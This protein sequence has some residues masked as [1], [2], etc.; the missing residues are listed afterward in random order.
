MIKYHYDLEQGSEEWLEAR[1]GIL[2]A[3]EMK[4]ILTP[5]L[6]IAN[7][8]KVRAH[9][10]E[11]LAQRETGYVEPSYISDDM[12]RGM[13]DEETARQL[14][15][16]HYTE[17]KECGFITNDENGGTVGYSPDGLVGDDGLIEIK[18]RRQKFQAET[19]S[20]NE[21]PKDYIM[22]LQTGLLVTGREWIDFVSYSSGMPLFIK[23]VLPDDEIQGALILAIAS[24][25]KSIEQEAENYAKNKD[26]LIMTE[27]Q[28][29]TD[30]FDIL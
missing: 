7:N 2:T 3:S 22:Q 12:L 10:Y 27:R 8:E 30:D 17:T 19:I 21:V 15:N 29:N 23:R 5:T 9:V 18:S 1:R 14:Y 11:L 25:E 16:K 26:G 13:Y 4:L 24:F 20:K 28:T 6:K